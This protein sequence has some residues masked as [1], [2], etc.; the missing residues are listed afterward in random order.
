[1]PLGRFRRLS[2]VIA[3][4]L[5]LAAAR[6]PHVAMDDAACAPAAIPGVGEHDETQ[7]VLHAAV[8]VKREHCAVCHWTR[9]LRSPRASLTIINDQ[10]DPPT[11][12]HGALEAAVASAVLRHLPARAPPSLL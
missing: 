5:L 9:S 7:H 3:T 11:Q 12:V 2:R 6:L 1:M 8:D 4:V 10:V